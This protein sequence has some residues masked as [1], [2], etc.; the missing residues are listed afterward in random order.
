M[1]IFN[2]IDKR[3]LK[4]E[5]WSELLAEFL[6]PMLEE[7]VVFRDDDNESEESSVVFANPL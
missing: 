6:K 7:S 4:V 2:R 3:K 1:N 5:T